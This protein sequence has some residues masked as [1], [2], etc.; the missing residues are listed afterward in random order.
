[1]DPTKF[2]A[3]QISVH[4]LVSEVFCDLWLEPLAPKESEQAFEVLVIPPPIVV[5]HV[6]LHRGQTIV[7]PV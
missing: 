6:T 7:S 5:F 1:N 4:A 3:A 2:D